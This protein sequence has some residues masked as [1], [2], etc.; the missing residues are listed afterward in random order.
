MISLFRFFFL[1]LDLGLCLDW[2]L[3][4][5]EKGKGLCCMY[6]LSMLSGSYLSIYR[7]IYPFLSFFVYSTGAACSCIV[8]V[9]CYYPILL[10]SIFVFL[11]HSFFFF[12]V[13]AYLT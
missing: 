5:K 7:F 9:F 4:G 3:E 6:F 1:Q 11:F 10:L 8:A 2:I 13:S 12:L